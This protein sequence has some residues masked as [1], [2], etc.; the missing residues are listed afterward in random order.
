MLTIFIPLRTKSE[1]NIREHWSISSKRHAMQKL[2][3]KSSCKA[4]LH[5]GL[6]PC[7]VRM[8]RC[9]RRLDDDNLRGALKYVRDAIA[10]LLV[11][12]KAVGRADDDPGITWEYWQE[13]GGVDFL[14]IS[15]IIHKEHD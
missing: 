15:A 7:I 11:P 14:I 2:I 6:L 3:V 12:G 1:M 13:K 5:G 4:A 9:G 8:T 10:E